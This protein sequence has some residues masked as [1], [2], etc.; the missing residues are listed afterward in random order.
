M[1]TTYRYKLELDEREGEMLAAALDLMHR[2]SVA[3]AQ[4]TGADIFYEFATIATVV[5]ARLKP[6]KYVDVCPFCRELLQV[7]PTVC[8]GC[9]TS[10][11]NS[12]RQELGRSFDTTPRADGEAK[13]HAYQAWRKA[14]GL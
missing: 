13:M 14:M 7:A 10:F 11:S 9:G 2:S 5:R 12:P 6:L 1:P 8:E 4:R 3:Q